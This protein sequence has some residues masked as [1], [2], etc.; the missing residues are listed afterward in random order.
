[1]KMNIAPQIGIA[2]GTTAPQFMT[3]PFLRVIFASVFL[4]FPNCGA[5]VL[6]APNC[7]AV[8]LLAPNCG[9]AHSFNLGVVSYT[10]VRQRVF[11]LVVQ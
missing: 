1:M 4:P 2:S 3:R 7:G 11:L 5:V 6:L 10:Y 8:V 9:A